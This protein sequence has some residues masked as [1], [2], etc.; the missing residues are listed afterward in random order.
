MS[1]TV[2][3]KHSTP[4]IFPLTLGTKGLQTASANFYFLQPRAD[5][6]SWPPFFRRRYLRKCSFVPSIYHIHKQLEKPNSGK[7]FATISEISQD[8]V[9]VQKGK[10]KKGHE[11]Q[12]TL[13]TFCWNKNHSQDNF[14]STEE[15]TA[16]KGLLRESAHCS[17][18]GDNIAR[19]LE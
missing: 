19:L 2:S 14:T 5:H 13:T 7:F 12:M 18:N 6:G 17:N 9:L 11:I 10:L 4:R 1:R 16:F 3:C 15:K 8:N